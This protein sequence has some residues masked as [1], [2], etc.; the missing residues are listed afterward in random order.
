M[1]FNQYRYYFN[2]FAAVGITLWEESEIIPRTNA[3][4]N[5]ELLDL[6]MCYH[7]RLNFSPT[8]LTYAVRFALRNTWHAPRFIYM[9]RFYPYLRRPL[10]FSHAQSMCALRYVRL[11]RV[12]VSVTNG[13]YVRTHT[14]AAGTCLRFAADV[15]VSYRRS[16]YNT[17]SDLVEAVYFI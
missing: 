11:A 8:K 10:F 5:A 12:S 6:T 15:N 3:L 13:S 7:N 9:F 1:F 17:L 2:W 16:D 14:A 4:P